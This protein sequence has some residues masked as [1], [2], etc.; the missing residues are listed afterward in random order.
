MGTV[1][2]I[3]AVGLAGLGLAYWAVSL[4][5]VIWAVRRV[6]SLSRLDPPAP[7]RWPRLSV[8]IPACN[9]GETLEASVQ[10][11][12]AAEYPDLEIVVVE[13]RSTDGTGALADRLA[14]AD[15]RVRVVH[16][17]ELPAGWLGKVNAMHHGAQAATG[18]WLLFCDADVHL[19]PGMLKKTVAWSE[20]R[21]LD[22]VSALPTLERVHPIV[23]AAVAVVVR[24]IVGGSR[25]WGVEDPKSKAVFGLGV[26]LLARRAAL[27]RTE[28]FSWLKLEVADDMGLALLMKRSGARCAALHAAG[29]IG[30]R[31]YDRPLQMIRALEKNCFSIMGR[32]SLWRTLAF[33]MTPP[34]F[35]LSPL[36]A[37][38]PVDLIWLPW[39]GVA[40]L[41]L[42][43]I[44]TGL[45]ARWYR[46]PAWVGWMFPVGVLL[47]SAAGVRAALLGWRR[48]GVIWRGTFY[49]SADLRAGMR[50]RFPE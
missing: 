20:A 33:A 15:P 39:L 3:V 28:G 26:F 7:E 37:F 30:I 41:G 43:L 22:F 29:E 36:A 8:I 19:A 1:G 10:A 34:L 38:L 48:G 4:A 21:G 18:D 9:E 50:V 2:A 44:T 11:L 25:L 45:S 16:V 23:D 49:R 12:M 27:A 13:D 14:L 24:L 17:T 5:V 42:A 47:I 32:C 31:V 40:G 35:E 46:A 6:P